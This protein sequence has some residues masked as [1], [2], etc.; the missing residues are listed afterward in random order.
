MLLNI[1]PTC[2]YY[3]WNTEVMTVIDNIQI[4]WAQTIKNYWK[5]TAYGY[6]VRDLFPSGPISGIFVI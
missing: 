5:F 4:M 3:E 2:V 1:H 6:V